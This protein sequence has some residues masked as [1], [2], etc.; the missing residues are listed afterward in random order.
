MTSVY[1]A[2]GEDII[3]NAIMKAKDVNDIEA[4]LMRELQRRSISYTTPT[5]V[6]KGSIIDKS[7]KTDIDTLAKKGGYTTNES[8]SNPNSAALMQRYIAFIKKLYKEIIID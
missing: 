6:L 2:L 8:S 3:M 7:F 4:Y 1:D 5:S